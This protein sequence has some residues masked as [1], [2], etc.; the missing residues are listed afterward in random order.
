[1]RV[2]KGVAL[3]MG[4]LASVSLGIAEKPIFPLLPGY[5]NSIIFKSAVSQYSIS[6]LHSL[7]FLPSIQESESASQSL[8]GWKKVGV[9]SAECIGSGA[10]NFIPTALLVYL[11][12]WPLNENYPTREELAKTNLSWYILTSSLISATTVW[13]IGSLFGDRRSYLKGLLG[14]FAGSIIGGIFIYEITWAG[15][16]N[17]PLPFYPRYSYSTVGYYIVSLLPALGATI[18][19]NL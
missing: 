17:R 8:S 9:M 15:K 6:S 1:M 2:N 14:G 5:E 13:G 10:L 18:G 19:Y 16:E 3:S 7:Y 4:V 11:P 12:M